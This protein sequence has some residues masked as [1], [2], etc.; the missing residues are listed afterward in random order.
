MVGVQRWCLAVEVHAFPAVGIRL[1]LG[2]PAMMPTCR[3]RLFFSLAARRQYFARESMSCGGKL[4][5]LI[6]N[7]ETREGQCDRATGRFGWFVTLDVLIS[8]AWQS[9]YLA[10]TR[11]IGT[12][13]TLRCLTR[14][15]GSVHRFACSS[16][17][18][19]GESKL[20]QWYSGLQRRVAY[21]L[22]V[23]PQKFLRMKWSVL[24]VPGHSVSFVISLDLIFIAACLV[25]DF[26]R[27][28]IRR[29]CDIFLFRVPD[30]NCALREG[31]GLI[32][33]PNVRG[34]MSTV[35]SSYNSNIYR[36]HDGPSH[37]LVCTSE[38]VGWACCGRLEIENDITAPACLLPS[39]WAIQGH[40]GPLLRAVLS[41][42]QGRVSGLLS[43][44]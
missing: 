30:L 28:L 13:Y 32:H 42:S 24:G 7:A 25:F 2:R 3:A 37:L 43:N 6:R 38:M 40:T 16:K 11:T 29:A 19:L 15:F 8:Y 39:R 17:N 12:I 23:S 1:A 14:I 22:K 33:S 41:K 4:R 9:G 35:D 10:L 31:S 18:R 44:T 21:S 20:P 27:F 5:R 36:M 34:I 26:R